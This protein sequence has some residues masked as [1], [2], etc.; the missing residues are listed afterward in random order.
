MNLQ[1]VDRTGNVNSQGERLEQ[2]EGTQLDNSVAHGS[3]GRN[4][5]EETIFRGKKNLPAMIGELGG[6]GSLGC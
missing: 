3:K 6:A 1:R 5:W 2:E 4:F